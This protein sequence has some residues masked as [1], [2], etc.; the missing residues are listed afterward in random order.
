M[1]TKPCST[2]SLGQH[3]MLG[4]FLASAASLLSPPM[5]NAQQS[6]QNQTVAPIVGV[7]N[8][9]VT[10]RDCASGNPLGPPFPSLV[11]FLADGTIVESSGALGFA[12]NQRSD[13]QGTWRR[14]RNRVYQQ[15][16]V[17][18]VRFTTEPLPPSPGFKAGY[19]LIDHTVTMQNRDHFLSAGSGDFYD[20][21]GERYRSGCSTAEGRRFR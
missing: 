19:G 11:S 13:G 10:L 7:W 1:S 4:I 12:P 9:T 20:T 5:S 6:P 17:S 21:Q 3:L 16:V 18:L 2:L 14:L 8:V 15:R